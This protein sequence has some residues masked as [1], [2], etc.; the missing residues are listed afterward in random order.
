[1]KRLVSSVKLHTANGVA[2]TENV[3]CFETEGLSEP[4]E[5]HVLGSTPNVISVGKRCVELGYRFVWEPGKA[6]FLVSPKRMRIDL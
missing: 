3:M 1:M 2:R 5:A 4:I 6:P